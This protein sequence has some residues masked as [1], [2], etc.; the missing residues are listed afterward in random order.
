MQE[1]IKAKVL[2]SAWLDSDLAS[3]KS[4]RR[5][6]FEKSQEMFRSCGMKGFMTLEFNQPVDTIRYVVLTP[7]FKGAYTIIDRSGIPESFRETFD[8]VDLTKSCLLYIVFG[9]N[10]PG[11]VSMMKI[12]YFLKNFKS[13]T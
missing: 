9:K 4:F 11:C 1:C 6:C 12:L 2:F 5:Y 13:S 7:E 10:H 3:A 8:E